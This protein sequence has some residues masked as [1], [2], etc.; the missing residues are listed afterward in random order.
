MNRTTD[1][2]TGKPIVTNEKLGYRDLDLNDRHRLW[3]WNCPAVDIDLL[4]IEY[5]A[6]IPVAL[7]EYKHEN[8]KAIQSS[9]PSYKAMIYLADCAKI[10]MIACQYS[11]D[12]STWRPIPLNDHARQYL[13][14]KKPLTERQWVELLYTIRGFKAPDS[15]FDK[16]SIKCP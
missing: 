1:N 12:F 10:P 13:P 15:I 2:R 3:G 11:A 16:D 5:N 8:C 7:V 14:E 4:F 9:H 6:G